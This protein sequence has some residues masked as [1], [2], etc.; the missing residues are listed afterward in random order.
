[1]VYVRE[2]TFRI[3]RATIK[4]W[5]P[6]VCYDDATQGCEI[7]CTTGQAD[8][9]D[10]ESS[11]D[12]RRVQLRAEKKKDE[13]I[14]EDKKIEKKNDEKKYTDKKKDEKESE[15]K[16]EKKKEK[17]KVDEVPPY[18]GY[19]LTTKCRQRLVLGMEF[20]VYIVFV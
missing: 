10:E 11:S 15:E 8:T 7:R 17:K 16:V 3:F 1:M 13:K 20:M 12:S 14:T 19:F 6:R 5:W 9:K 18:P 4:A 2:G